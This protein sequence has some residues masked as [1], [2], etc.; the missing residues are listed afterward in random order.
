MVYARTYDVYNGPDPIKVKEQL[1]LLQHEW[2][3]KGPADFMSRF[4][5]IQPKPPE[6]GERVIKPTNS[7]LWNRNLIPFYLNN[8][9]RDIERRL[10][11]RNIFLKPRQGGYTTY[12]II[13]RLL[14]ACILN[15]GHNGLL[16]AQKSKSA[17]DYFR[18]LKRAFNLF[19]VTDPF[20]KGKNYFAKELHK[21]LLHT[22]YSNRR[23]L[24]F[25]QLD[26]AIRCESAEVEEVGQGYCVH[27]NTWVQTADNRYVRFKELKKGDWVIG[28]LGLPVQI[29]HTYVIPAKNHPFKGEAFK[30]FLRGQGRKEHKGLIV[31][32]NHPFKTQ[33][34][35]VEAKDLTTNDYFA[36]PRRKINGTKKTV[37]LNLWPHGKRRRTIF[38]NEPELKL[39]RDLGLVCGLYLADGFMGG[40]N[41]NHA[42]IKMVAETKKKYALKRI[43]SRMKTLCENPHYSGRV[44]YLH[45]TVFGNWVKENFG[46]A[47]AKHIPDWWADAP[48][49]F[50]VGL[51]EGWLVGDAWWSDTFIKAYGTNPAIVLGMKE[52]AIA[53][54][55]MPYLNFKNGRRH[56]VVINGQS[57]FS[58]GKKF[59]LAFHSYAHATLVK[60]F[61]LKNYI[62]NPG[63]RRKS[64]YYDDNFVYLK[65]D[66][67]KKTRV[68][69]FRDITVKS[70]DHLYCLPM[71]LTHNTYMHVVASEV[72]RW[73]HNPEATLANLKE[74]IPKGGTFD[75]ESTANGYGGYFFEEC[76]RA[77][78][79]PEGVYREFTYHFHQWW[80][81]EEYKD[82]VAAEEA[83]ITK[84]EHRLMMTYNINRHQITWR[85]KKKEELRHEFDEKY[86]EDDISCFLLTGGTFFD[87]DILKTRHMEL[88]T[89]KPRE[90]HDKLLIF[91]KEKPH[92][93]YIIGVDVAEGTASDDAGNDLD[94]SAAYVIDE[95]TG[96]FVAAYRDQCIPE[97][98]GWDISML[99]KRYNDALV[100]VE[101]NEDGG[102]VILTLEVACMY[103]NLYKH[104]DWWKKDWRKSSKTPVNSGGESGKIREILGWPTT[105]KTRPIA[106]NRLRHFI[107]ESPELIYD[108]GL[109]EE[110]LTFTRNPDKR[111]R[112]EA[113]KGCHD[114]RVMAAAIALATRQIRLGYLVPEA[115]PPKEKYGAIPTEFQMDEQVEE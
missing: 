2:K 104:R 113:S 100:A 51:L 54:G 95:E 30:I 77:R 99:G 94:W 67:I 111:G 27:P 56:K 6:K 24:V 22:V 63:V 28:S 23:E 62:R 78:N 64:Q 72:A 109:V 1:Q 57:A 107:T 52:I 66:R 37:K 38:C 31:A 20:D 80:F 32:P 59:T 47:K 45:S 41:Y 35:M 68:K 13:R 26:L 58:C 9:Q 73:E 11:Q 65:I 42:L 53:L 5:W 71:V 29:S 93:R 16:I 103:M 10:G 19:A 101:R 70:K 88:M 7:P 17:S 89:Y 87:R 3:I 43:I 82:E 81:H 14:L 18:I 50:L 86:P 8:I 114:D 108:I 84:D 46:R 75:M 74:S 12:M 83:T 49:E 60:L 61:G 112:P 98:L 4:C 90:E 55:S 97:E 106:L 76:M 85:R 69:E 110:C 40:G 33:R 48:K 39:D 15:P 44:L 91:K 102:A 34:G 25:D 105:K 79:A 96:E 92:R 115:L 21:H 36:Y